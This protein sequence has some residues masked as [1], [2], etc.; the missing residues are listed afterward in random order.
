MRCIER[1]WF[2][3]MKTYANCHN[4]RWQINMDIAYFRITEFEIPWASDI[5]SSYE[6]DVH[7]KLWQLIK[8]TQSEFVPV[9]ANEI[10]SNKSE[11]MLDRPQ[12]YAPFDVS[13][14]VRSILSPNMILSTMLL[15]ATTFT[16][17]SERHPFWF[18]T[19]THTNK[20]TMRVISSKQQHEEPI[21]ASGRGFRS[22]CLHMH[23]F[24]TRNSHN[25]FTSSML[26]SIIQLEKRK[27]LYRL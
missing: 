12:R 15:S 3:Y 18:P 21:F 6:I 7:P 1:Q 8:S 19:N 17:K 25:T 16:M 13:N 14:V 23:N 4:P 5:H 24:H 2:T 26:A 20:Y 10:P 22:V 27:R 9:L 11:K